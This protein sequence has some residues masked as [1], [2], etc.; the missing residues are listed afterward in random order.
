MEQNRKQKTAPLY[1][2]SEKKTAHR[3]VDKFYKEQ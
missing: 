1:N 2:K 3:R